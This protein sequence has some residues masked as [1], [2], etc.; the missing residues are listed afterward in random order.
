MGMYD[1]PAQIDKVLEVSG[2]PKM[3]VIGYSQ[4]SAQN[5]YAMAKK[6][7]F[8]A[9]RVNRFI[10]VAVCMIGSPEYDSAETHAAEFLSEREEGEYYYPLDYDDA[11]SAAR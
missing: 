10:A 6:Q 1:M 2:K 5:L 7:D 9:E 3:T 11:P 8:F 4:G